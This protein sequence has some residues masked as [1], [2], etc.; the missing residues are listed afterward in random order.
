MASATIK[1]LRPGQFVLIDGEPCKVIDLAKSKPGKHGAAKV[2]LEGMGIFDNRRRFLL[3]P[4][5]ADVEVPII[6]K[7]AAQIIT[8]MG[9]IVQLMDLSDYATFEA[10]IPEEFKGKLESGREVLYWKISGK[11][12]I[13]ELR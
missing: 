6:E 10:A 11:I 4:A 3:K 7:K 1:E 13:K 2:R 5:S 8:V 12:L 9:D